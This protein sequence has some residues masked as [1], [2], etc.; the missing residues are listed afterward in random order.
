MLYKTKF[1]F[2]LFFKYIDI[3][4]SNPTSNNLINISPSSRSYIL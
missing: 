1:H 3:S 4:L 2:E